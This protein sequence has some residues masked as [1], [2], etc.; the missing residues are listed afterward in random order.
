MPCFDDVVL[1]GTMF[2]W[3]YWPSFNSYGAD[4]ITRQRAMV[5]TFYALAASCVATFAFSVL[6]S[7][8]SKLHMVSSY[9]FKLHTNC[10]SN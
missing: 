1:I 5:N 7:S 10:F 3:V 6:S 8:E 2:L 9:F 4:D